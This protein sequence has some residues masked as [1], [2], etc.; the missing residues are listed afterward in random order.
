MDEQVRHQWAIRIERAKKLQ[1]EVHPDWEDAIDLFNCDYYKKKMGSYDEDFVSVNFVNW[2]VNNLIPLVYFRDPYIFVKPRSEKHSAFAET[3]EKVINYYWREL[4]LKQEFKRV[5]M[6]AFLTTPGWIKVGYFGEIGQDVAQIEE[7]KV[8][9]VIKKVTDSIKDFIK[10][11]KQKER[12]LIE[13]QGIL[14]E[15]IKEEN[16][17]AQWIPSWNILQPDGYHLVEQMPYLIEVEDVSI[18]DLRANPMYKDV[19]KVKPSKRLKSNNDG[20][21]KKLKTSAYTKS[22]E[23]DEDDSEMV[24][25][26]HV[27]DKRSRTRF[28]IDDQYENVI[29][30]GKWAYDMEGFPYKRLVFEETLP[31]NEKAN[32]YPCNIIKSIKP[33]VI[34]QSLARTQMVKYRKRAS[35]M[36]LAQKGAL[37]EE[38]M[39]QIANTDS[40]QICYVSDINA[41]KP[42]NTAPLPT[43]VFDVDN[44]IKQD[45]QMATNM[46]QM[47]F[48]AQSGQRTATQAQI[49][50][51]GLQL[52]SSA[53]VD[54]V[55]DFTV[56]V[57]K[58]IGQLSWQFFDKDKVSEIIGEEVSDEMWLPLPESREE[59]RRIIQ[60][61]IQFKIDAGS[62]A[63]PKDETVDRKQLLD[64]VSILANF[65]PEYINKPETGKQLIKKF[66]FSKELDK[67]VYDNNEEETT[68][69][70]EENQLLASNVPQ[71]V[72]PNE[73]H[74][75]HIVEHQ[76]SGIATDA[77]DI[78]MVSHGEFMN[79]NPSFDRGR[80]EGA[81]ASG[82]GKLQKGDL[83]PPMASTNPEINR[84]GMTNQG[85]VYQSVQNVGV[86]SGPEAK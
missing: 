30:E 72:S 52:K 45:L 70:L 33:Q 83:R 39:R 74:M 35:S 67:I 21:T 25:L 38:D 4:G 79:I 66:K 20:D 10:G 54:C 43:Q 40:V 26:Y 27:W 86:G 81:N 76:K 80:S 51:S 57:A 22:T 71:V 61:E 17:F 14:N 3:L 85:D 8:E 2:Y 13:Q 5:I 9:N 46:G 11:G 65:M 37:N 7:N 36:I 69:A 63:P 28:T 42:G 18:V 32:P 62:A 60:A 29:F 50:Q 68:A 84:Q 44:I 77:M 15:F 55:E 1:E 64:M 23:Q 78:H 47:M 53:R 16:V 12:L 49:G 75:I 58:S 41:V 34:E 59:R 6:S 82:E 48:Q 24:R 31:F 56:L 73:N 19:D